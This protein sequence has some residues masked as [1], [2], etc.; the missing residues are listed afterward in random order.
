MDIL[1]GA[2]RH[3]TKQIDE[4]AVYLLPSTALAAAEASHIDLTTVPTL[5]G[6]W[7]FLGEAAADLAGVSVASAGDVDGDGIWDVLIGASGNG[8]SGAAYLISGASL[9]TADEADGSADGVIRLGHVPPLANCWKFAGAA[10]DVEVGKMVAAGD[11]GSDGVSEL[12]I[13]G[14]KRLHLI[15]VRHLSAADSADG[16]EDGEIDLAHIADRE[17]SWTIAAVRQQYTQ[18]IRSVQVVGD[19]DGDG[20]GDLAIGTSNEDTNWPTAKDPGAAYFVSATDLPLLDAA[21]GNED[22]VVNLERIEK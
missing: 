15:S 2:P 21:D 8:E 12:L 5:P 20:A 9:T 13:G 1:I 17:S 18:D 7:K 16:K 3:D 4:G 10:T 6:G 11:I 22:G 14:R 19:L